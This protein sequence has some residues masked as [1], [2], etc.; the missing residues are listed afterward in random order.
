MDILSE[1]VI[2]VGSAAF[3]LHLFRQAKRREPPVQPVFQEAYR[4]PLPS[5][6]TERSRNRPADPKPVGD[7]GRDEVRSPYLVGSSRDGGRLDAT[8]SMMEA[9]A[10]PGLCTPRS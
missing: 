8:A 10:G 7:A 2:G 4:P 1:L 6:T 9:M 3:V 5:T